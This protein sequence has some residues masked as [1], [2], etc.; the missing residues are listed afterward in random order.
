MFSNE[1]PLNGNLADE[2]NCWFNNY[3]AVVLVCHVHLEL[4]GS[5][6]NI[7]INLKSSSQNIS[8]FTN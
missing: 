4:V 7:S 6:I 1:S 5:T 2:T 8:S 3:T